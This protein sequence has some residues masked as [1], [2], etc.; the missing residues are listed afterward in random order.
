MSLKKGDFMLFSKKDKASDLLAVADGEIVPLEK[1]PDEAFSSGVLGVGFAVLP[2]S[3]VIH[4]PVDGKIASV[5]ETGHAYTLLTEDGLDVLIHVGIDTVELRGEG[6]L[7]LVHEGQTVKAGD[8]LS[9]V[10]LEVLRQHGLATHIP[11]LVTNPERLTKHDV[12]YGH[13]QGGKSRAMT[14]RIG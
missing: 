8:V 11:V 13:V 14:Y 3:G 6:F 12:R 7:T 10:D 2:S 5:T 4:S 1:V 9:R